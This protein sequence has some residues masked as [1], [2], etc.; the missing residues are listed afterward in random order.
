MR[1]RF[2]LQFPPCAIGESFTIGGLDW[3]YSYSFAADGDATADTIVTCTTASSTACGR[4]LS[5]TRG[6]ANRSNLATIAKS[7]AAKSDAT[8]A[9]ASARQSAVPSWPSVDVGQTFFVKGLQW[10]YTL[11]DDGVARIVTCVTETSTASGMTLS[12]TGGAANRSNLVTIATKAAA[13]AATGLSTVPSWAAKERPSNAAHFANIEKEL[14]RHADAQKAN[15]RVGGVPGTDGFELDRDASAPAI[16]QDDDVDEFDERV[17]ST[18]CGVVCFGD[19]NARATHFA[20]GMYEKMRSE[21][22][23]K[24]EP[25][26]WTGV[27]YSPKCVQRARRFPSQSSSSSSYSEAGMVCSPCV[28]EPEADNSVCPDCTSSLTRLMQCDLDSVKRI[29]GGNT[30]WQ[31]GLK[32]MLER[33]RDSGMHRSHVAN[34][35]LT[36]SQLEMRNASKRKTET[37][38]RFKMLN[39]MRDLRRMTDQRDH[40]QALVEGIASMKDVPRLQQ[41]ISTALANNISI[42]KITERI[43]AASEGRYNPKG[44]TRD[45]LLESLMILRMGGKRLL[46]LVQHARGGVSRSYLYANKLLN[47]AKFYASPTMF[48][49][50]EKSECAAY[51]CLKANMESFI[52][53]KPVLEDK[54]AWTVMIDDVAISQRIEADPV[55]GWLLGQCGC[56]KSKIKEEVYATSREAIDEV[57]A[58][59]KAGDAHRAKVATVVAFGRNA[60]NGYAPIPVFCVGTCGKET[61]MSQQFLMAAVVDIWYRDPRGFAARGPIVDIITDGDATFRLASS[62]FSEGV[63]PE[64]VLNLLTPLVLFDLAAGLH[65]I[66]GGCDQ[67]HVLKRWRTRVRHKDGVMVKTFAFTKVP[68]GKFLRAI[69]VPD[70]VEEAEINE[71]FRTGDGFDGMNVPSAMRMVQ[72]IARL[73]MTPFTT[74]DFGS[75]PGV[76]GPGLKLQFDEIRIVAAIS[77]CYVTLLTGVTKSLSDHLTN[78]AELAH[79]IFVLY[80]KSGE[81][82]VAGQHYSNVQGMIKCLFAGVAN[83]KVNDLREFYTFLDS[84]DRLEMLFGTCRTMVNGMRCF[85]LKTLGERMGGAAQMEQIYEEKKEWR[86]SSQ[87]LRVINVG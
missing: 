79:L 16:A 46:Y 54:C 7:V 24:W 8:S 82:F 6:A 75:A 19:P 64:P 51:Q 63:F 49:G 26:I 44:F 45:E 47:V 60:T 9:A 25:N 27:I 55:E 76:A 11:H 40:L 77:R 57:A 67:K 33:G 72:T 17:F 23:A 14:Q 39:A 29:W 15:T 52:F 1:T 73:E 31:F 41:L 36:P 61:A 62:T 30:S 74:L 22:K 18:C 80:R 35:Y 37:P 66:I 78:A 32:E 68:F 42:T 4:I 58:A 12:V 20:A 50:A 5:V 84:D 43:A 38:A 70:C 83:G 59:I 86:Q 48:R 10:K 81:H 69:R 21:G 53:A 13:A 71:I 56:E 28:D 2:A 87:H 65:G 3:A 85:S 34:I